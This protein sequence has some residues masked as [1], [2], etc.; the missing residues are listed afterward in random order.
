MECSWVLAYWYGGKLIANHQITAKAL[1][2]TFCILSSTGRAIADAGGMTTDLAKG[3]DAVGSV[4]AILDR[5]SK[6]EPVS[7]TGYIPNTLRGEVKIREVHFAYPSRPDVAIYRGFSFNLRLGKSTALVGQS[8]SGKS[9]IISLIERFYDPLSG[10]VEIDGRDIRAYNLRALRR[11]IG[12]VSQEPVLFAGTIKENI[13]FGIKTASETEIESAT[14]SA[15]AH[16]F[17][18][19]L[20]DGYETSCGERGCQLSGGQKQRTAIARAILKN[21]AI[22]LLDEATSAL[23]SQSEK[24]VQEAL[25]QLMIGRTSL[26]VAHRLST[27][28]RCDMIAVLE[29][30]AVVENGTHASLMRKV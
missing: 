25:D 19:N 24:V 29:K 22:L 6:I 3:A 17:I 23:D 1:F 20:K 12:L 30:G 11:H 26:V 7:P 16:E 21:P 27:I 5:E 28:Q 14:R 4:F 10:V 13:M 18:S 9:T 8:G 15:N 2:Q